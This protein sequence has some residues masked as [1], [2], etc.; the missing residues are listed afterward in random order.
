M[1]QIR[2][3]VFE[4]NSSSTHSLQIIEK[5]EWI[6]FENGN[7]Y[8]SIYD[9]AFLSHDDVGEQY[10]KYY[11]S[12]LLNR[13]EIMDFDEWCSRKGYYTY[14]N[15]DSSYE[16]LTKETPDGEHFAISIYGSID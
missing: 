4:T 15:Y 16:I 8:F 13:N 7:L 10:H 9:M 12:C 3:G 1:K 2:F 6:E 14:E 5:S 11:D